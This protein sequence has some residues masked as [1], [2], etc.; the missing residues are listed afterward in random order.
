MFQSCDEPPPK[1]SSRRTEMLTRQ[2]DREGALVL[3]I[4]WIVALVVTL[5]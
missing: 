3:V 2:L 5:T 4:G 1:P